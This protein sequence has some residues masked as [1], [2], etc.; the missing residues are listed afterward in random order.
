MPFP[1]PPRHFGL[2][3]LPTCALVC[4]CLPVPLRLSLRGVGRP[5]RRP[6]RGGE[7]E[8][9]D[10]GSGDGGDVGG[11]G[12][13]GADGTAAAAATPWHKGVFEA[14]EAAARALGRRAGGVTVAAVD[15]AYFLSLAPFVVVFIGAHP[16]KLL[17]AIREPVFHTVR[18]LKLA[19][20]FSR[21]RFHA[22]HV[23]QEAPRSRREQSQ[24]P[25][26]RWLRRQSA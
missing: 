1:P 7:D 26:G 14:V 11:D 12:N 15:K 25:F 23:G 3:W 4:A 9:G 19:L 5:W 21:C 20:A 24:Q 18:R 17:S 22:A 10:G 16:T 13:D 6:V 8:N 2:R